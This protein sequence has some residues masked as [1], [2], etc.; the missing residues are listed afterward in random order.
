[1]QITKVGILTKTPCQLKCTF[2]AINKPY[3]KDY[4]SFD[5]FKKIVD[6]VALTPIK[7]IEITP[8]IG[9]PLLDPNIKE[10]LIYAGSRDLTVEVHTNLLHYSRVFSMIDDPYIPLGFEAD[11]P[12]KHV[13]F[14]VS[15]YGYSA[16]Q[17]KETTGSDKYELFREQLINLL[18]DR[19]SLQFKHITLTARVK[20][21]EGRFHS[22]FS[23]LCYTSGDTLSYE[24]STFNGNWGGH[25]PE[26]NEPVEHEGACD[27]LKYFTG[28]WANG[29]VS[30]CGCHDLKKEGIV[31]NLFTD[32]YEK[33]WGEGGPI[34]T[35][36]TEQEA[37]IYKG[38]CATCN[39]HYK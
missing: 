32:G 15:I 27:A 8:L 5:E 18:T 24:V 7:E 14:A 12:Y 21:I 22:A 36:I 28:I 33:I 37:G 34:Q 4:M 13:K 6:M 17:Y 16:E 30:Y 35:L 39:Y 38:L 20:P 25:M 2:C 10:K 11:P 1:M 26:L 29:D 19:P 3:T 9:D 23:Q 31:G